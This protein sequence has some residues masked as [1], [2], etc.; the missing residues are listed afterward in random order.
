VDSI[1]FL[2]PATGLP[3]GQ[4][5]I[6]LCPIAAKTN[7]R[8]LEAYV[9]TKLLHHIIS[10]GKQDEWLGPGE[11]GAMAYSNNADN[12]YAF[13]INRTEPLYIPFLSRI[14]GPFRYEF[15]IGS[16]H[17]HTYGPPNSALSYP[18]AWVNPGTP[19]V[20]LEKV[21]FRPTRNLEFGFERTVIWG[22]KGH[23]PVT[24]HTFLRSFFS[25]TAPNEAVKNSP[26]DPGA[27]FGAFDF[28]YRLPFIRNW[29]TLYTDSEAHD[30]VSPTDA[31]QN[32]C[33]RAGLYL[34]HVPGAPKLDLRVE[35]VSTDPSSWNS[36]L[37]HY[38]YWEQ[39][40]RQGYTNKGSLFGDWIGREDKGGQG[41]VTYH[42]N[43]NE[44]IQVAL[45]NQKSSK[46]FIP[47]GTT[48]NEINFQVVK[49][50]HKD[51]EVKGNFAFEQW[52]APIYPTGVPVYPASPHT[53]TATTIQLTWFPERRI[54][55]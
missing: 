45:R 27:R 9:S 43:G 22:S 20:H 40:Q 18:K 30:E 12:I 6:P 3:Y 2:N 48:L 55:F 54:G 21:S 17:G 53:V 33:F 8:V 24:L 29:L 25:L 47:G 1:S 38:E 35:G 41:W 19:W 28:S 5:T 16:L 37:G 23:E 46:D 31:P 13:R 11:G 26:A 51:F 7:G 49:R 34:S 42:L 44:W 36:L 52:K 4:A 50:I 10:F 39:I 15:L 32:A 14:T